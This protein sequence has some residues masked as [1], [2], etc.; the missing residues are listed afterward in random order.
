[1]FDP[2]YVY[3]YSTHWRNDMT[4]IN[5]TTELNRAA[6]ASRESARIAAE[7]V[8]DQARS[9]LNAAS[10]SAQRLTDEFK[11]AFS[12]TGERGE[13]LKQQASQN[14]EALTRTSTV[15]SRGFQDLSREWFSLTQE[16]LQRNLD[17]FGTLAR[18]RSLHDVVE[19]QSD[20]VR[21][22]LQRTADS[23]RRIAAV[24]TRIA[25]ETTETMTA[26]KKGRS[27]EPSR[28]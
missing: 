20:L 17:G 10:A 26:H 19:V 12:F 11:Q 18:C 27:A 7:S 9:T 8:Q 13:E 3:F 22:S 2:S 21:D 6:N 1:M 4:S 5:S 15:L 14:L 24:S 28:K 23:T 25:D 16:Q